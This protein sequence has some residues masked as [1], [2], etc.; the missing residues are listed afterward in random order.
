MYVNLPK[1]KV[2]FVFRLW[3]SPRPSSEKKQEGETVTA[4]SISFKDFLPEKQKNDDF[5]SLVNR[6][7]SKLSKGSIEGKKIKQFLACV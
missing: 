4:Q 2:T 5:T 7:N 3:L 6:A 1:C